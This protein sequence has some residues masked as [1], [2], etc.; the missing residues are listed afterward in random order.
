VVP[1]LF[2]NPGLPPVPA[3]PPPAAQV[4]SQV[5]AQSQVQ[6]QAGAGYNEQEQEQLQ[7]VGQEAGFMLPDE[8]KVTQLAMSS[9]D[10][11]E[12]VARALLGAAL[13]GASVAGAVGYRRRFAT[14]PVVRPSR[15]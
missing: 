5:Q 1:P 10:Q 11:E 2:P 8:D 13:I 12:R 3:N 7:F 4:Q 9:R 6:P 14:Q 15:I